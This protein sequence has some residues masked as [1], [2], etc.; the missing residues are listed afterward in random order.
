MLVALMA[1]DM[2]LSMRLHAC[3]VAHRLRKPVVGMVY[4]PK[5]ANH[6]EQI[7]RAHFALKLDAPAAHIAD[8][9]SAAL[10]EQGQ[11]PVEIHHTL[12]TLEAKARAALNVTARRIAALP[13]V[14]R[15][16]EVPKG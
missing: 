3:L 13:C 14:N 11:V 2:L 4:D 12:L 1:C 10:C 7:G 5:V 16:F 6:F 8:A 15:V 9:I